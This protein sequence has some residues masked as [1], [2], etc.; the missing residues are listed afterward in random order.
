VEGDISA[1]SPN[2]QYSAHGQ[3]NEDGTWRFAWW[4]F[5]QPAIVLLA[6]VDFSFLNISYHTCIF[7]CSYFKMRLLV[8]YN[9]FRLLSVASSQSVY[10]TDLPGFQYLVPCAASGLSY[11]VQSL[12]YSKCPTD[13]VALQSCEFRF[14]HIFCV[15]SYLILAVPSTTFIQRQNPRGYR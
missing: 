6:C 13:P 15:S 7:S 1:Y 8:Y 2:F 10:I 3:E 5:S 4:L 14:F 12:T 9:L 11:A